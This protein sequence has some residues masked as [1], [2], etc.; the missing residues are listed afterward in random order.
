MDNGYSPSGCIKGKC[1]DCDVRQATELCAL[2][3]RGVL[4]LEGGHVPVT[5][6]GGAQVFDC[7]DGKR[8]VWAIAEGFVALHA[9]DTAGRDVL[10]RVLGP[11]ET[12]GHAACFAPVR[13]DL[14][15]TAL[16]TVHC[17]FIPRRMVNSMLRREPDMAVAMMERL[18]EELC[19]AREAL[20]SVVHLC[21][22]ARLA[23]LLVDLSD[24]F[25]E[26]DEF[27]GATLRLPLSRRELAAATGMRAETVARALR[28]LS[29]RGLANAKG[30][31][32]RVPSL[33]AL[34]EVVEDGTL[35]AVA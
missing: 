3:R 1:D 33:E 21:G 25:G 7:A 5:I 10:V 31:L 14:R 27:G 35:T 9:G 22:A 20:V 15:A 24:R 34:A 8:G 19:W 16:T 18:A 30:R 6:D 11:G 23:S 32:V 13:P 28:T 17:C 29:K 26:L 12:F 4:N 2:T